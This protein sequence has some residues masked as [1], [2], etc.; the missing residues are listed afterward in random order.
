MGI[1]AAITADRPGFFHALAQG[2]SG[3]DA[4]DA[5]IAWVERGFVDTAPGASR[6]LADLATL[7]QRELL[8]SFAFP[9][10]SIGGSKDVIAD[11]AI[12]GYAA[13]C[14]RHG[15]LV[16]LDTGHSPQLE[17]PAVYNATLLAFVQELA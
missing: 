6:T 13:R 16:T 12:A 15:R 11:P 10:L 17:N 3:E 9:F 1:G 5:M 4:S 2:A 14:A 8:A 7:D